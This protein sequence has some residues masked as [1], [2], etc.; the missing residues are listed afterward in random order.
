MIKRN[1]TFL[2]LACLL[3]G[4][5][6]LN[7][8]TTF[9]VDWLWFEETGYSI[10]FTKS[11]TT[12]FILGLVGGVIFFLIVYSNGLLAKRLARQDFQVHRGRIIEFPQLEGLKRL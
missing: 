8:L 3:F 4:M 9:W 7:S 5:S 10:L 11:V 1:L 6:F 12:Q 2:I